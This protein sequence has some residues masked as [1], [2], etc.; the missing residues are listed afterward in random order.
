MCMRR[1]WDFRSFSLYTS[2]PN[3]HTQKTQRKFYSTLPHPLS[4]LFDGNKCWKFHGKFW[5][6]H[7]VYLVLNN[8]LK[9]LRYL[10]IIQAKSFRCNNVLKLGEI[11]GETSGELTNS[12]IEQE[13]FCEWSYQKGY[14]NINT[15]LRDT[16]TKINVKSFTCLAFSD[17][18]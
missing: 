6:N 11:C 18:V 9:T 16:T 7:E 3:S 1:E 2:S 15:F 17:K 4:H 13:I 5:K 14:S 10:A 12:E 8:L